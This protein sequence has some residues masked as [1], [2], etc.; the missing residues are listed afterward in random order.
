METKVYSNPNTLASALCTVIKWCGLHFTDQETK[1]WK[2][3]DLSKMTWP[4]MAAPG[5]QVGAS[6]DYT[7]NPTLLLNSWAGALLPTLQTPGLLSYPNETLAF[8]LSCSTFSYLRWSFFHLSPPSWVKTAFIPT[9][10]LGLMFQ[11][12]LYHF[13]LRFW[14]P[15][16]ERPCNPGISRWICRLCFHGDTH[17]ASSGRWCKLEMES[18]RLYP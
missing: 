5:F 4:Q 12:S 6:P 14:N 16:V 2:T 10:N 3:G 11:C 7:A 18:I 1:A 8:Q 13:S 9:S 17:W 15:T